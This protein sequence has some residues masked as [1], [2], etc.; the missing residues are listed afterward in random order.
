MISSTAGKAKRL[1]ISGQAIAANRFRISD[2]LMDTNTLTIRTTIDMLLGSQLEASTSI[3]DQT[4]HHSLIVETLTEVIQDT[5]I[6]DVKA[7]PS[8][9]Q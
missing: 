8:V 9:S 3:K 5:V 6:D 4:T 2:R 7:S 1:N